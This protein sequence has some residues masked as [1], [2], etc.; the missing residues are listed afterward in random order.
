MNKGFNDPDRYAQV[1]ERLH[2]HRIAVQGCFVFGMDQDTPEVCEGTAKFAVEAG[3]DLPRF[4]IA[5]PF[6]GTPLYRRLER[7]GRILSRDWER[8]DGQHVVF[9][10]QRMSE[11]ELEAATREAWRHAYSWSSIRKRLKKT[12]AP[13]HV[14]LLSNFGYRHYAYN[15]DRYYSC[16]SALAFDPFL[17]VAPQPRR[18][19]RV[20]E[21]QR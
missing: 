21:G 13:L 9:R 4:A 14:A 5:T 20:V 6:P 10:P 2:R 16:D 15:L 12:A 18:A 11:T 3:I 17:D 19:L 1:V 7:E 8:Y